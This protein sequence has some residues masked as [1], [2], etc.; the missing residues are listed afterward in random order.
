MNA[1]L[2]QRL[3]QAVLPAS[4][5]EVVRS[6]RE[7]GF[8]AYLVGGCVRDLLLGKPPKDFDV[9]TSAHPPQVQQRFKKVIPTGIDHGTVTVLIRGEPIEVTTFRTEADYLDGRRPSRVEFHTEIEADLSRRDFTIN[10]MAFDPIE[11]TLVD[12][13]D[14]QGDL[15]RRTVRCVGEAYDRFSEDGLRALRAVRFATVLEFALDARTEA[16]IPRTLD[17]FSKVALE[18]VNQELVK[19]L[20]ARAPGRGAVLLGRTG[21][22]ARFLPELPQV[23]DARAQ[24]LDRAKHSLAVRLAVLLDGVEAA[25]EVLF[26]L[27]F[28]TRTCDEVANLLAHPLPPTEASDAELRRWMSAIGRD[29]VTPALALARAWR[30]GEVEAH[31]LRI[32]ELAATHPPLATRELALQGRQIMDLLGVGPSPHVGEAARF[33]LAQVLEDPALNTGDRLS[34]LLRKWAKAQGL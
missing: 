9:A 6:L 5:L 29:G 34:D 11:R 13:F 23:E 27:K 15:A 18:R 1:E 12:P 2:P 16:A 21:L 17:V 33:L 24:A 19:L 3:A 30:D 7:G 28:P 14:G 31:G 25:R 32:S 22:L 20:E 10:A 8:A 26:R 4:V